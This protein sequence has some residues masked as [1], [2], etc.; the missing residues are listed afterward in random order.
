MKKLTAS[1]AALTILL[2]T[3]C[4]SSPKAEAPPAS[5]AAAASTIPKPDAA[6]ETNLRS[7][8][9]KINPLFDNEKSVDNSRNQCSSILG[10]SPDDKL[11]TS[12]KTR[13]TGGQVTSVSDV[14]AQQIIDVIKANGFCKA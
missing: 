14:E 9:A 8:L 7:E 13:F 4:S 11:I 2:A 6:Q 3:G 10:E 5:T 1:L 12:A